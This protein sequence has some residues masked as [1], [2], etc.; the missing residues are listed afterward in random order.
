[1]AEWLKLQGFTVV[2]VD[3]AE[4]ADYAQT[5]FLESGDKPFTHTLLANILHMPSDRAKRGAGSQANIDLRI[6]VGKDFD[7]AML[8]SA[9]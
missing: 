8:P 5:M 7:L 1:V 3:S 2:L 6:I 9:Q 4:R